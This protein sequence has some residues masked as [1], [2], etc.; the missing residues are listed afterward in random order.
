LFPAHIIRRDKLLN[1]FMRGMLMTGVTELTK[2]QPI[3]MQFFI[4]T[5]RIIS[6]FTNR[7]F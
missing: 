5:R 2:L 4:L 1:F 6:I 3:L 7:T